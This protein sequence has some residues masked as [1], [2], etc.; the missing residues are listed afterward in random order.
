MSVMRS[1]RHSTAIALGILAILCAPAGAAP[2]Q[3]AAEV[4]EVKVLDAQVQ[5]GEGERVDILYRMEVLSVIRSTSQVQPGAVVTVRSYGPSTEALEQGW[6]GSAYVNPDTTASGSNAGRQFVIAAESD[7]LVNLPPAP[8][9]L[10]YT[11]DR[12]AGGQ[13]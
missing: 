10:E 13:R 2:P 12:P 7:S 8:P 3:D 11:R 1:V 5:Q 9:S 6:M 4:L